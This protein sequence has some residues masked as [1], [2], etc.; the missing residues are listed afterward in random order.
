MSGYDVTI[1]RDH[2]KA[3]DALRLKVRFQRGHN[4]RG[5]IRI[6]FILLLRPQT[7]LVRYHTCWG[8]ILLYRKLQFIIIFMVFS[9][10]SIILFILFELSCSRVISVTLVNIDC[11]LMIGVDAIPLDQPVII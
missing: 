4:L 7:F 11:I 8:R 10:L 3:F 5:E 2:F 9:V 6:L 1:D